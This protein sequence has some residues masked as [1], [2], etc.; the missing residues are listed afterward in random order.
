MYKV[1]I[2]LMIAVVE[3]AE[4]S[5]FK[6]DELVEFWITF[7]HCA[8]DADILDE[9][10]E[11]EQKSIKNCVALLE[12]EFKRRGFKPVDL[13]Q[14]MRDNPGDV[15]KILRSFN[16]EKLLVLEKNLQDFEQTELVKNFLRLIRQRMMQIVALA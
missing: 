6:T 8:A 16:L 13:F 12:A 4:L 2:L 7:S 14:M 10:E 1:D 11:N 3:C 9:F 15:V 5:K